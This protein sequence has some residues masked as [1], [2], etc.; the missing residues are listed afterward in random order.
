ML[1]SLA[2]DELFPDDVKPVNAAVFG[3]TNPGGEGEQIV[4]SVAVLFTDAAAVKFLF[5]NW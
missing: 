1:N 4:L 2:F 3:S 5:Q